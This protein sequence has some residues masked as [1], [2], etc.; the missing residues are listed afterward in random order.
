MIK[1]NKKIK[2]ND[3]GFGLIEILVSMAIFLIVITIVVQIF[4]MGM[5]GTKRLFGRQNALDSA[6]FIMESMS[7]ELRMSEITTAGGNWN[8]IDINNPKLPIQHVR[9]SFSGNN[10][11][12]NIIGDGEPAAVLNS[13]DVQISNG[14]FYVTVPT[15]NSPPRVTITIT[16]TSVGR[17]TQQVQVNLQTTVSSRQYK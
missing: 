6:R 2:E 13:N 8:T 9:Y 4:M 1:T 17:A 16:V 5:G 11:T 14:Q 7:K 15:T 12:R 3:G 10:I